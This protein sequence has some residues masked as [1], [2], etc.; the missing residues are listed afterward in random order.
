MPRLENEKRDTHTVGSMHASSF[1]RS[2]IMVIWACQPKCC[3]SFRLA[4]AQAFALAGLDE[5]QE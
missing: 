1:R 5:M 4:T 3:L 2:V